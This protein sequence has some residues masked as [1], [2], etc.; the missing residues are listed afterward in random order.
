[1]KDIPN[2]IKKFI[3]VSSRVTD[4]ISIYIKYI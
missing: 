1:M 4:Y 3:G 2:E